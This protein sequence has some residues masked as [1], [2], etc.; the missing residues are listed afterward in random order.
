MYIVK[1][2]KYFVKNLNIYFTSK[3]QTLKKSIKIQ[4][5]KS[6]LAYFK[7]QT[8]NYS[9]NWFHLLKIQ[10]KNKKTINSQMIFID[11]NKILGLRRNHQNFNT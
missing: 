5:G 11:G 7:I 10:E 9:F 3:P 4:N 6:V 2:K 8:R 1:K